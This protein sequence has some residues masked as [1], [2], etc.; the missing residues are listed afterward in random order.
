MPSDTRRTGEQIEH[1]SRTSCVPILAMLLALAGLGGCAEQTRPRVSIE[2]QADV[3]LRRM[4]TT[5]GSARSFSVQ[6]ETTMDEPLATGQM[7]QFHRR[8][9]VIVHRPDRIFIRAERAEDTWT[10]WYRGTHLTL[11]DA[12]DNVYASVRVPSR[13]DDMLDAAAKE[14]GLTLP[15]ADLLF[16]DPYKVLTAGA[17]TGK[18]IGQPEVDGVRMDHLLFTHDALDWQVWIDTGAQAVPRRIVIDYK[19]LPGR[20]QCAAVLSEWNLSAPAEDSQFKPT[21]PKDA[22]QVDMTTL[23]GEAKGA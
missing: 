18:Y 16:S 15:L 4:S 17:L 7:A 12:A 6:S 1:G 11:F 23:I 5:L 10:L 19:R 14:H 20:P 3:A 8:A 13:I 21:V 22:Q 9:N 2:P